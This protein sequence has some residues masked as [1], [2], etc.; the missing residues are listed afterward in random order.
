MVCDKG[1]HFRTYHVV[2]NKLW[3]LYVPFY[4]KLNKLWYMK[5]LENYIVI[6][7]K[8]LDLCQL[9]GTESMIIVREKSK[10]QRWIHNVI[11]DSGWSLQEAETE[12]ELMTLGYL[13][14]EC[15]RINTHRHG[16]KQDWA[17][18]ENQLWNGPDEN[19]GW[20]REIV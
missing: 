11:H 7:K 5:T 20:P 19:L 1:I 17:E 10:T 3:K 16:K 6:P 15:F 2:K 14:R 18:G 4:G 8:A 13:L 9:S 12:M